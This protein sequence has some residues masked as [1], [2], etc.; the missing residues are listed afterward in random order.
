MG[1]G[2]AAIRGGGGRAAC[3]GGWGSLMTH[4]AGFVTTQSIASEQY[5][6]PKFKTGHG[7][8]AKH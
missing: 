4:S 7:S 5:R 1:N 8:F 6:Q 2:Y 3:S